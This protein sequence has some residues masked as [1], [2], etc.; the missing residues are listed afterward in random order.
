[1][2]SYNK[3]I[4]ELEQ[5]IKTLNSENDDIFFISEKGVEFCK[6]TLEELRRWVVSNGFLSNEEEISFYKSI[7][8]KVLSK[9]I[10]FVENFNIE[11][12]RPKTD[13]KAQTKYYNNYINTLQEYFTNNQEF[14]YYFKRGATHLDEQY[15]LTK[16]AKVRL[17][18]EDYQFLTDQNFSTSHCST[19]ATIIAYEKL[20]IKLKI[21]IS[22][23]K[24]G[25]K[26]KGIYNP[27]QKES[28]LN[29]TGNKTDLIEL[30][31]ALHSSG[32]INSGAADIKGVMQILFIL[33][34]YPF[35]NS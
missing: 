5:K 32:S 4:E 29:W 27:F 19:L 24:T 8:P 26:M 2:K 18:K 11:S 10:Y 6:Y 20:I 22:K 9:L 33:V 35:V 34:N 7:K 25:I 14:F 23:L 13:T 30:I 16:N 28:N 1:M 21:E 31:Y 3:L 12:K 17:N 15:F